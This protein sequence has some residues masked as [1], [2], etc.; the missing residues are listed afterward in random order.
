MKKY[1]NPINYWQ[2]ITPYFDYFVQKIINK[3]RRID[4][5]DID[6]VFFT[7]NSLCQYRVKSFS[8]K[9][10]KTLDWIDSF[11]DNAVVWDVGANIGLYSIYAA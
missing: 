4:Y 11:E 3:K 9:E 7:P 1:L 10:P 8:S 5:N 6:M 2:K